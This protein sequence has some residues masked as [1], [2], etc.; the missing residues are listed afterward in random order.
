MLNRTGSFMA[1]LLCILVTAGCVEN[2]MLLKVKKDGSGSITYRVFM[3]KDILDMMQGMAAGMAAE[4][5]EGAEVPEVDPFAEM[6]EG[7]AGQFGDA[8]KLVS[9]RDT[10]NKK[11]WKGFEAVYAFDDVNQLNLADIQSMEGSGPSM[12]E[13]G[14]P[15]RFAFTGG[16]VATL[17]IV[18]ATAAMEPEEAEAAL[19]QAAE[20]L[21]AEGLG[22][23]MEGMQAMGEAGLAMMKPMM[24]GMRVSFLVM[25]DGEVVETNSRFQSSKRPNVITLMD[26]SMDKVFDHPEASKLMMQGENDVAKLAELNV[27]GVR[28]EDPTQE[29]TVSFK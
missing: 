18:P 23:E 14:T 21:G 25:V 2:A 4:M 6:K 13:V 10:E 3:S 22:A 26:I 9:S 19:D 11:G 1:G 17:K 27:P 24:E 29:I 12:G 15:Y 8:A 7:L 5:G 16:D 20:G 28:L